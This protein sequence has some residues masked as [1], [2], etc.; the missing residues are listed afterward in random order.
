MVKQLGLSADTITAFATAQL[1][2]FIYLMAQGGCFT[3]NVLTEIWVPIVLSFLVGAAYMALVCLCHNAEDRIFATK[4]E[5]VENRDKV[6][7]N[8][9]NGLRT[10]RKAIITVEWF[11]SVAVLWVIHHGASAGRFKFSCP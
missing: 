5:T 1:L 8:I 4:P 6:V 9:V 3:Q 7:Q 2:A 11:A 10:T